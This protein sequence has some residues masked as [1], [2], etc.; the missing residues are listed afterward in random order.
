MRGPWIKIE[1]H[2]V[3]FE[4]RILEPEVLVD[5]RSIPYRRSASWLKHIRIDPID[6]LT[7]PKTQAGSRAIDHIVG[8]LTED[9]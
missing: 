4:A 3:G 5:G 2:P 7:A 8:L 6:Q 1:F 9:T